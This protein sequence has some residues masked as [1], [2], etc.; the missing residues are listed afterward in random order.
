MP[1][2][3]IGWGERGQFTGD[4]SRI[5]SAPLLLSQNVR[6]KNITKFLLVSGCVFYYFYIIQNSNSKQIEKELFK[7][8]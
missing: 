7:L 5:Q 3:K 4:N 1:V 8:S 2:W 6:R